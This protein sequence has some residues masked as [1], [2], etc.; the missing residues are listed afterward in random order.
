LIVIDGINLLLL[1]TSKPEH[2]DWWTQG[3][4]MATSVTVGKGKAIN[5]HSDALTIAA[6]L[7]STKHLIRRQKQANSASSGMPLGECRIRRSS[8]QMA[9]HLGNVG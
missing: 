8:R 7:G 1:G 9:G 3:G 6:G 4:C 5:P 2:I